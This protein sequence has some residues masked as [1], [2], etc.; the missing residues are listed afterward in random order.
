MSSS[1]GKGRQLRAMRF[2]LTTELTRHSVTKP[3][4]DVA[5]VVVDSEPLLLAVGELE[6]EQLGRL[7]S[8]VE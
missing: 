5:E 8:L 6:L 3:S 2:N 4:P 1:A 7:G